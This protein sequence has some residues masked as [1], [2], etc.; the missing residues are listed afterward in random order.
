[1]VYNRRFPGQVY[2][3]TLEVNY[4]Y[5]RDYDP[6]TGRYLQSDP[7]GLQ[8]GVNTYG[9][10]LGNPVSNTDPF[11]LQ[12]RLKPLP[13]APGIGSPGGANGGYDPRT[14][15]YTPP[16]SRSFLPDWLGDLLSAPFEARRSQK[17]RATDAPSWSKN[18][19]RDPREDCDDFAKR[20]LNEHY[21]CGDPRA[22][23]RGPGSE[24]S[25]IK[26]FCE[27]GGR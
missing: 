11:G 6:G 10:V 27:R 20:V 25:Q 15:T 21:G 18:Y 5:F 24:Y 12:T 8:G 22:D 19:S 26:K 17:E 3:A 9:Y 4:N 14:D 16:S 23:R 13:P 1:F 2:D 7:I